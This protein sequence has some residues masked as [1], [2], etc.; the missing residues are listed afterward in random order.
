MTLSYLKS[1]ML[2]CSYLLLTFPKA[3]ILLQFSIQNNQIWSTESLVSQLTIHLFFSAKKL[4]ISKGFIFIPHFVH[5]A[6]PG[7][8]PSTDLLTE[9]GK[10]S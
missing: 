8:L 4:Q 5:L 10:R 1:K 7:N 9:L 3:I 6:T 2:S